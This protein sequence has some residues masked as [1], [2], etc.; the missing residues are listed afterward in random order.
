MS[1]DTADLLQKVALAA[2]SHVAAAEGP[3]EAAE[4][5]PDRCG[6]GEAT[7]VLQKHRLGE[8]AAQGA[9]GALRRLWGGWRD[10]AAGGQ[11]QGGHLAVLRGV[12]QSAHRQSLL[13]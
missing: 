10:V 6:G 2:L 11:E 5:R 8:A 4:R 3:H 12:H 9:A 1:P 13:V 7:P